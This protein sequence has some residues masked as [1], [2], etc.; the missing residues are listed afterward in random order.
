MIRRKILRKNWLKND[1]NEL[2]YWLWLS[3]IE[4]ILRKKRSPI[5]KSAKANEKK[6]EKNHRADYHFLSARTLPCN[7]NYSFSSIE[8]NS[9]FGTKRFSFIDNELNQMIYVMMVFHVFT[10]QPNRK[11]IKSENN[12]QQSSSSAQ[13]LYSCIESVCFFFWLK[14]WRMWNVWNFS[15]C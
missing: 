12:D 1:P 2:K 11:L 5:K 9:S 7:T 6:E 15:L 10:S 14:I 4:I 3:I 13:K 8:T